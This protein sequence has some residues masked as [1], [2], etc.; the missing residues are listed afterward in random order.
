MSRPR[1]AP[2]WPG[3]TAGASSRWRCALPE[4]IEA[5]DGRRAHFIGI[6]L[7]VKKRAPKPVCRGGFFRT[8]CPPYAALPPDRPGGEVF[9]GRGAWL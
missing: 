5:H 1:A 7:A 3:S 6:V 2:G 8:N 9:P 4:R